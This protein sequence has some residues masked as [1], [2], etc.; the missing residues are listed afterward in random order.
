MK[1]LFLNQ[2]K[3]KL[4]KHLI[5]II[6]TKIIDIYPLYLDNKFNL[7]KDEFS[8]ISNFKGDLATLV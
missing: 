2:E 1:F 4:N 6:D 5:E 7:K 3:R 8:K